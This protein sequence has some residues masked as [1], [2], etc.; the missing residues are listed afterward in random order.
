MLQDGKTYKNRLGHL[1]SVT[2]T[3][4]EFSDSKY[5]FIGHD[6]MIYMQDGRYVD[7]VDMPANAYD[8]IE[9]VNKEV[10]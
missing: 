3:K 8:L 2:L 9:E 5:P 7:S 10:G 4:P 6:G 1:V